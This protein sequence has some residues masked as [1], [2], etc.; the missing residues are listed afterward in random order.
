MPGRGAAVD[1]AELER[2]ARILIESAKNVEPTSEV[3]HQVWSQFQEPAGAHRHA[4][5][6]FIM[7]PGSFDASV[8]NPS[9]HVEFGFLIRRLRGINAQAA[10]QRS[11]AKGR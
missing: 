2:D 5:R 9:E 1:E 11:E 4:A 7:G 3:D 6:T 8:G 10:P